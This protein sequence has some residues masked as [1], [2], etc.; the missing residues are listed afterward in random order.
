VDPDAPVMLAGENVHAIDESDDDDDDDDSGG[1]DGLDLWDGAVGPEGGGGYA[2]DASSSDESLAAYD[3]ADDRADLA[4]VPRPRNL[5]SCLSGLRAKPEEH[6][7]L[8]ISLAAAAGLVRRWPDSP[9][10]TTMA[11]PLLRALLH[12]ADPYGIPNYNEH[13]HAALL[14]LTVRCPR[15]AATFLAEQFY[16]DGLSLEMRSEALKVVHAAAD[17]LG[18]PPPPTT[19]SAEVRAAIDS[20]VTAATR[21]TSAAKRAT[22]AAA[23]A[24][25]GA[26]GAPAGAVSSDIYG[27]PNKTRRFGTASLRTENTS[28]ASVLAEVAPLFFFPLMA[29]FDEPANSFRLLGEDAF[30]LES[31]LHTLAALLRGAASYPCAQPMCRA[32]LEFGWAVHLHTEAAVRRGALVALCAVG[33]AAVGSHMLAN[34]ETVLDQLQPWLRQRATEDTDELCRELAVV[35]YNIFGKKVDEART[36]ALHEAV[37]APPQEFGD[38]SPFP[39]ELADLQLAPLKLGDL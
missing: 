18:A 20:V 15:E 10:L 6:E 1:D 22:S 24:P 11:P 39:A 19:P 14:A 21:A 35:C 12:M 16:E 2:S 33:Q 29:R 28:K 23:G 7:L 25:A 4:K 13:R 34:Y 31:L 26:A 9:E 32:L 17:E 5:R 3:L 36:E 27:N 30:L 37:N 38:E 8:E